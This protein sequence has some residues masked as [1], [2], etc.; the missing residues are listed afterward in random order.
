LLLDWKAGDEHAF[1]K[2]APVVYGEL[3]RM[4]RRYM[5]RERPSHTLQ[6]SALVN[7]A[8]LKLIDSRRVGWQNRAHFFAIS[9]Q[10]M[11]RILVDFARRRRDQKRGGDIPHVTFSEELPVFVDPAQN[12]TDL[13]DA[14]KALAVLDPRMERVVELRYFG[15]LSVEETAEVLQVSTDTVLRDWKFAKAWLQRELSAE[16]R[17]EP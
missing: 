12:V 16:R 1:E 15:G 10:L 6:P 9:A 5:G 14:L 11:R 3:R 4:A 2:L 7:E 13:D 8:F 17:N